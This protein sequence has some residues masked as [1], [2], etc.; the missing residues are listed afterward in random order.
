MLLTDAWARRKT[1]GGEGK[2]DPQVPARARGK[3]NQREKKLDAR[4]LFQIPMSQSRRRGSQKMVIESENWASGGPPRPLRA[5]GTLKKQDARKKARCAADVSE[6]DVTIPGSRRRKDGQK[7]R[8]HTVG[9]AKKAAGPDATLK[10]TTRGTR[11]TKQESA[12]STCSRLPPRKN[13]GWSILPTRTQI[14][15]CVAGLLI[16]RYE[17]RHHTAPTECSFRPDFYSGLERSAPPALPSEVLGDATT[18]G[19]YAD[20]STNLK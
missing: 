1:G 4:R 13:V 11:R 14:R 20:V 16:E 15:D 2:A 18:T 5:R 12:D 3:G 8:Q 6:L 10:P 9:G 17:G 7:T 19:R